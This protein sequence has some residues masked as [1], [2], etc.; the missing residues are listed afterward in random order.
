MIFRFVSL[1]TTLF[2]TLQKVD[3]I[4]SSP[5][6]LACCTVQRRPHMLALR[7]SS[8][9]LKPCSLDRRAPIVPFPVY[10]TF[11]LRTTRWGASGTASQW[12][13]SARRLARRSTRANHGCAVTRKSTPG[14]ALYTPPDLSCAAGSRR[15]S[16]VE[17]RVGVRTGMARLRR[18][19]TFEHAHPAPSCERAAI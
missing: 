1:I 3:D 10:S 6:D 12:P 8:S 5:R 9:S 18:S 7:H 13:T 4:V 16:C 14:L 19:R 2:I 15:I 11:S 17:A